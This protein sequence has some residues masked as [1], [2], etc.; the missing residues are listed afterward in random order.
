MAHLNSP[1]FFGLDVFITGVNVVWDDSDHR[2]NNRAHSWLPSL[3][4]YIQG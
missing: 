4:H 1:E 2:D 3:L